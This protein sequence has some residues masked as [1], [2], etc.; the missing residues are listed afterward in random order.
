MTVGRDG[1]DEG[2]AIAHISYTHDAL[3]DMI[4]AEPER[5]QRSLAEAFGY[6]EGWISRIIASDVFQVRLAER[7]AQ[8]VD[9]E[10]ARTMNE[11]LEA[12]AHQSLELVEKKL[13]QT[14]NP[15]Y[16]LEAL[17][18]AATALGYGMRPR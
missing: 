9:P 5:S 4:M 18:L 13:G 11:R 2:R 16:A 14:K 3:I 15:M 1:F 6:S 12:L 7:K 17:G 8:M 10:I